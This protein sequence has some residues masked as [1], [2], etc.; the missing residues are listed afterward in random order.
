[1]GGDVSG[2]GAVTGEEHAAAFGVADVLTQ[3]LEL[4]ARGAR[5]GV[6]AADAHADRARHALA[7]ELRE[8]VIGQ[9]LSQR[10]E[11]RPLSA[12]EAEHGGLPGILA[13][14]DAVIARDEPGSG[15]IVVGQGAN[16]GVPVHDL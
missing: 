15:V 11:R 13:P 8:Y 5:I 6:T 7:S 12:D 9:V 3:P 14:F 2:T 1:E 4:A 10:A 16:A